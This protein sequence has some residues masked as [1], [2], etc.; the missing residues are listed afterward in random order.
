MMQSRQD[1]PSTHEYSYDPYDRYAAVAP[2]LREQ[3]GS[4]SV[5]H[6]EALRQS[7]PILGSLAPRQDRPSAHE[8][9][10]DPYDRY[11]AVAPI[12]REQRGSKSVEHMKALRQSNPILG[13]LAPRQ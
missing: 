8:Y 3:R 1:R 13:S 6:M 7:N 2:M 12:L 9:S 11:A 10:Y 5:E 4:K